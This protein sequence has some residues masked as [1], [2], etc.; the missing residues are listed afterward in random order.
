MDYIQILAN[1]YSFHETRSARLFA[2]FFLLFFFNHFFPLFFFLKISFLSAPWCSIYCILYYSTVVPYS[3]MAG[4]HAFCCVQSIHY[5]LYLINTTV[6]TVYCNRKYQSNRRF[7]PVPVSCG[8][9][10][11]VSDI[12][13][14][15]INKIIWIAWNAKQKLLWFSCIIIFPFQRIIFA[16]ALSFDYFNMQG[17][18]RFHLLIAAVS[19]FH[20]IHVNWDGKMTSALRIKIMK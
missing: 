18:N 12:M 19:A 8:T 20:W 2:L 5:I 10:R 17:R 9:V 13:K 15:L 16:S 6:I 4:T 14:V 7:T 1:K 3:F 11:R